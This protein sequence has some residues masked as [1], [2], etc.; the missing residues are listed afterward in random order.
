MR[1]FLTLLFQDIFKCVNKLVVFVL[2]G[3]LTILTMP[4]ADEKYRPKLVRKCL[5]FS[6]PNKYSMVSN[7]QKPTI[8]SCSEIYYF[9]PPRSKPLHIFILKSKCKA[10]DSQILVSLRC[11]AQS[12]YFVL[13]KIL[14]IIWSYYISLSIRYKQ[15]ETS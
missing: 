15:H 2:F 3:L 4:T 5:A 10:A 9:L 13:V 8:D 6:R 12:R 14:S 1:L 7:M 11:R